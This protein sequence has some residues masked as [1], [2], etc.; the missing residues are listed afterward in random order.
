MSK[1]EKK[2]PK[3]NLLCKYPKIRQRVEL[4]KKELIGQKE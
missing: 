1:F 2:D 4:W 3:D